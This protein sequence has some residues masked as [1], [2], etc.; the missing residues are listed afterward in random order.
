MKIYIM[1]KIEAKEV[2]LGGM[3]TTWETFGNPGRALIRLKM[4]IIIRTHQVRYFSE[5]FCLWISSLCLSKRQHWQD[6]YNVS[7]TLR[8]YWPLPYWI[9]GHSKLLDP[10]FLSTLHVWLLTFLAIHF[11][12]FLLRLFQLWM[13]PTCKYI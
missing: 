13:A 7:Q 2:H 12:P 6:W 4:E 3:A 8:V 11:T 1:S 5:L 9:R 10:I